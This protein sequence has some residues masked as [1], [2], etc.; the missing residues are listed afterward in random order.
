[1]KHRCGSE[2][3]GPHGLVAFCLRF[4]DEPDHNR[5][6]QPRLDYAAKR[7]DGVSTRI[8][9]GAMSSQDAKH[10]RW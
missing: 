9:P 6:Y 3:V 2:I 8:H 10:K 4:F 7:I 5:G 1:M